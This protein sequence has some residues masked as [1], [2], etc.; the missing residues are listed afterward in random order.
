MTLNWLALTPKKV[1]NVL[2]MC[3][4]MHVYIC[5]TYMNQLNIDGFG[6][7]ARNKLTE[8]IQDPA[9]I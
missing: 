8:K 2:I 3:I 6:E 5:L 7:R 4:C 1:A 9:G